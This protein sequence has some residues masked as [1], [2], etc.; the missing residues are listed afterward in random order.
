MIGPGDIL[1]TPPAASASTTDA[2]P[3]KAGGAKSAPDESAFSGAEGAEA[4]TG[5]AQRQGVAEADAP[6]DAPQ[7]EV[8]FSA[9]VQALDVSDEAAAATTEGE[10][11]VGVP[12]TPGVVTPV[13]GAPEGLS[14]PFIGAAE[15]STDAPPARAGAIAAPVA[16]APPQ[17]P[18][19]L[20]GGDAPVAAAEGET[21]SAATGDRPTAVASGAATVA[22]APDAAS[23]TAA[24]D[25][26]VSDAPAILDIE[27]ADADP[28]AAPL[29][30]DASGK[31]A[32]TASAAVTAL[33][34]ASGAAEPPAPQLR[35]AAARAGETLHST[36]SE[37]RG[38]ATE[39]LASRLVLSPDGRSLDAASA[40]KAENEAG[41]PRT[42][43][44]SLSP[45]LFDPTQVFAP[46]RE[47]A[48]VGGAQ[49]ID[50]MTVAPHLLA[51]AG[52]G[53]AD[54]AAAQAGAIAS[55]ISI[56]LAGADRNRVEIRLDPPELGR[57]SV[58]LTMG[59]E[60][61]RAVVS[62]ERQD[63]S[64]LMRRN[65]ET[66]QRE[67]AAAGFGHVDLEFAD[68]SD[69]E[70]GQSDSNPTVSGDGEGGEVA[71][72]RIASPQQGRNGRLDIRL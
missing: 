64:D 8:A 28:P 25:A 3:T 11:T 72:I 48:P 20:V 52:A 30:A 36:T 59:E 65:G 47:G 10:T 21:P 5:L 15:A 69:G 68:Q 58:T 17:Q 16:E 45:G 61:A 12:A 18:A 44:A 32:A 6:A 57:V 60:T 56:A 46:A 29:R 51:G 37:T 24:A 63:I 4:D 40:S 27:A 43:A 22:L 70:A 19:A 49:R 67:L 55:Q 66:L 42:V 34:A 14:A 9:V 54:K 53:A 38:L 31:A 1:R 7:G 23:K 33:S 35:D 13:D 50:A 41:G 39:D 26:F 2:A 62:V 71:Q